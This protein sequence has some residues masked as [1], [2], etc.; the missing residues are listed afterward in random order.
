MF[1]YLPLEDVGEVVDDEVEPLVDV[2]ADEDVGLLEA[3][4]LEGLDGRLREELA[5]EDGH[6]GAA[7]DAEHDPV[8]LGVHHL[9][10]V[11]VPQTI[12]HHRQR[13]L[14]KKNGKKREW[15]ERKSTEEG[16][17]FTLMLSFG[18][19]GSKEP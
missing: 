17:D 7:H 9:G 4:P 3:L 10:R 11:H 2:G 5:V 14:E 18:A 19:G 1:S 12:H 15:E 6:E 8:P 13:S 16:A